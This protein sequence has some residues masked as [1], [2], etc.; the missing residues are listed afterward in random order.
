VATSQHDLPAVQDHERKEPQEYIGHT[1]KTLG[2]RWERHVA[3]ERDTFPHLAIKKYG[4]DA[5]TIE[6]IL[7]SRFP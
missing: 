1:A 6:E 5:F 7:P 3:I 4:E 2:Q